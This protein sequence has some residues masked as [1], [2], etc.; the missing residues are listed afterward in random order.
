MDPNSDPDPYTP[1]TAEVTDR[2]APQPSEPV[3]FQV[4]LSKFFVM[5]IATLNLY[6]V[7]W[8]Y[9]HFTWLREHTE[10]RL[11]PAL[12]SIFYPVT[13]YTLFRRIEGLAAEQ[14][15]KPTVPAGTLALVLF[16]FGILGQLPLPFG[17]VTLLSVVVLLPMQDC[18][19]RL[20]AEVA[21]EAD[22]NTT[23]GFW[24]IG[25]IVFAMLFYGLLILGLAMQG[26]PK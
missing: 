19:N 3:L 22:P 6:N 8:F 20:N 5:S 7:Y 21:P 11:S 2:P 15:I 25:A 18:V 10:V 4:G 26:A 24:N 13:S 17:L 14:G 23:Y 16:L 12:R 1:P 9:K